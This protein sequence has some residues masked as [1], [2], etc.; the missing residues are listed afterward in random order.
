[1]YFARSQQKQKKKKNENEESKY[2]KPKN[3]FTY[4]DFD[5]SQHFSW[6]LINIRASDSTMIQQTTRDWKFRRNLE[7]FANL[8][9]PYCLEVPLIDSSFTPLL[10]P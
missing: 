4:V 2:L 1:M 5:H 7:E 3:N 6:N 10:A 8:P 9:S